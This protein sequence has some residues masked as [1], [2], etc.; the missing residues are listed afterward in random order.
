MTQAWLRRWAEVKAAQHSEQ[1][2]GHA[3]GF[4]LLNYG[5]KVR[6]APGDAELSFELSPSIG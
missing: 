6:N 1:G 4:T 2:D 5:L 3:P